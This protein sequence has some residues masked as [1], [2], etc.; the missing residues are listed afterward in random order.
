MYAFSLTSIVVLTAFS[1]Y[2]AELREAGAADSSALCLRTRMDFSFMA[3]S[4]RTHTHTHTTV[5]RP[6]VRDY[7]GGPIPEETF[8]HSHLKRIVGTYHH[9]GSYFTVWGR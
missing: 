1:H 9:A 6:F 2:H 8:T 5:L 7:P 3:H 4:L